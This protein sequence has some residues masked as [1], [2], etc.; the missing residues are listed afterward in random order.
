MGCAAQMIF[1]GFV[2]VDFSW[3]KCLGDECLEISRGNVW[4]GPRE[5]NVLNHVQD[6]KSLRVTIIIWATFVYMTHRHLLTAYI[7]LAQIAEL[8]IGT[9]LETVHDR[10]NGYN[11]QTTTIGSCKTLEFVLPVDDLELPLICY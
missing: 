3:G 7:L 6:Y 1:R 9:I 4:E 11:L 2:P 8:H 10:K 5:R